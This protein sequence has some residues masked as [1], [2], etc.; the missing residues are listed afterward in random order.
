MADSALRIGPAADSAQAV[1]VFV[2]GRGQTPEMM[3]AH[4]LSRLS[5]PDVAFILPRAASGSWYQA[6]AIDALSPATARELGASL[7]AI[8]QIMEIVPQG[9]PLMLAGFSQGA[10]LVIEYSLKFGPKMNGLASLTGCRVGVA[11]DARPL[12][13]LAGLPVYLSGSDRDPWIPATAFGEAA[14]D[15]ATAKAR[16]RSDVFPGRSHE[17]SNDEIAVLDNMIKALV[18]GVEPWRLAR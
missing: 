14:A 9:K 16:L 6:R 12:S 8:R 2:H 4:V 7:E 17:V 18:K 10:C 3:Q 11:T 5:L 15:L 1:C 13:D